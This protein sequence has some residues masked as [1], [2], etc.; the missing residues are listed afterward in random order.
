M[1]NKQRFTFDY[2]TIRIWC[3]SQI[4][5]KNN[6]TTHFKAAG[7]FTHLVKNRLPV[8]IAV[9]SKTHFNLLFIIFSQGKLG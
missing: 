1:L 2:T 9:S 7:Y 5:L 3:H 4:T 6:P 8:R